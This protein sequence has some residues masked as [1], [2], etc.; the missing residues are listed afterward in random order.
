MRSQSALKLVPVFAL[1]GL[2]G[3]MAPLSAMAD[4]TGDKALAAVDAAQSKAKTLHFVYDVTVKSPDKSDR[5]LQLDVKLKGDK[6]LTEFLAPSDVKGTKVLILSP[7]QMYIY[8]PSFGK[9]RRIASHTTEQGFMGMTFSQDDMLLT[10]YGSYYT[11]SVASDSGGVEKLNLTAKADS[12]APYAKIELTVDKSNNL[13][14]KIDY[15]D[16]SGKNV[17]TETRSGYTCEG[18]VCTPTDFTMVDH[19]KSEAS[20][21]LHRKSLKVN[22]EMSDDVFSKR[23]LEK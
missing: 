7:T 3:T 9:V 6:R 4:G 13:P 11:A 2:V 5:A 22:E 16:D 18:D 10:T 8:L 21:T 15:F 12:G 23:N 1:A 14:T 20:T 17:K 19:T